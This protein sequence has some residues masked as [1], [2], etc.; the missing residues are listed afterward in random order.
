MILQFRNDSR[1]QHH[2]GYKEAMQ[3]SL[4]TSEQMMAAFI[5][6]AKTP[7]DKRFFESRLEEIRSRSFADFGNNSA[8]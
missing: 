4:H 5:A 2:P 1:V 8:A 7:E 3:N 6:S